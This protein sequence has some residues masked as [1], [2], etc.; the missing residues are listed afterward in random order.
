MAEEGWGAPEAVGG[1]SRP[2][3]TGLASARELCPSC[4]HIREHSLPPGDV[5]FPREG[6]WWPRVPEDRCCGIEVEHGWLAEEW[7]S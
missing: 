4:E 6:S 3:V 2:I 5:S 7:E 1:L